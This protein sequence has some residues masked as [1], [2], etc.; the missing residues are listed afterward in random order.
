M[1]G[2]CSD[3]RRKLIR[4]CPVADLVGDVEEN[5]VRTKW[6]ELEQETRDW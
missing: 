1:T 6:G 5:A 2:S 3:K 4:S